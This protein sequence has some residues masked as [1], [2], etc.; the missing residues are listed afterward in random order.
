[1]VAI[2]LYKVT[3]KKPLTRMIALF[4]VELASY[5]D[6]TQEANQQAAKEELQEYLDKNYPIH[7]AVDQNDEPIGYLVCR[8]AERVVW[9]ESLFVSP[10]MRRKGIGSALYAEAEKLAK[11]LGE[12]T[13]YNWVHPTNHNVI[14]FLRKQGYTVLNLIE[15]RR[16]RSGE[17]IVQQ[18]K[19]GKHIF[20]Y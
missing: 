7:V 2:R 1:M 17:K 12:D 14:S 4:R 11:K 6:I 10:D 18:M 16:R 15:L 13:V 5:R 20:D 8:I 3:D 19:V 9:A